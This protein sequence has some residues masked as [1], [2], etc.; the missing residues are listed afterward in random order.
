L[1]TNEEKK[2][3]P[4]CGLPYNYVRRMKVSNRVY[5]YAVHV[6]KLKKGKKKKRLCYLGPEEE[7]NHGSLFHESI[8]LKLEGGAKENKEKAISYLFSILEYL[9]SV[10]LDDEERKSIVEAVESYAR[11]LKKAKSS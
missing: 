2:I 11:E 10:K 6:L 9:K 8:G 5:L 1:R 3:C 4:R 7:Y